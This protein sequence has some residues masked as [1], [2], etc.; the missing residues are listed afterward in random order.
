MKVSGRP[1]AVAAV[2]LFPAVS[3]RAG[4]LPGTYPDLIA[5]TV[6]LNILR[7]QSFRTSASKF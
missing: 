2:G 4:R 6:R 5:A 7:I 3:F 1:Q